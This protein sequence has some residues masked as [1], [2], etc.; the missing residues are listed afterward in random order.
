MSLSANNRARHSQ[1]SSENEKEGISK[2]GSAWDYWPVNQV[3]AV[4]KA[5]RQTHRA[6]FRCS[7]SAETQ[8]KDAA[9][10][11]SLYR[12]KPPK[13]QSQHVWNVTAMQLFCSSSLFIDPIVLR[14]APPSSPSSPLSCFL[15]IAAAFFTPSISISPCHPL[16]HP[17]L[18]YLPP[19]F[20]PL[21]CEAD[22][23][24]AP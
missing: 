11:V 23:T 12:N 14:P 7:V 4:V 15:L 22:K 16:H 8:V 21:L 19:S 2:Q 13:A 3:S 6:S 24:W 18:P 17:N 1:K 10:R 5:T 20:L 9:T